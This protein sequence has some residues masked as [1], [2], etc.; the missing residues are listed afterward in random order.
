MTTLEEIKAAIDRLSLEERESLAR[1]MH[2]WS[3]D[4]IGIGKQSAMQLPASSID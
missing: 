3:D 2:G 4:A 1:W